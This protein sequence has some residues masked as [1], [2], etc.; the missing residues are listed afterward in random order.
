MLSILFF[1]YLTGFSL[2]IDI[3][4]FPSNVISKTGSEVVLFCS[5]EQASHRVILWYQ[6]S[7]GDE[8]LKLIGYGYG[9]FNNDSVEE[10]FKK[11]F[12]LDGDL[13]SAK[14]NLS[15]SIVGLKVEHTATY[16][17]ATR[18]GG[19]Y[20]PAYFGRG[21]KLTVLEREVAYPTV[22]VFYPSG[23]ESRDYDRKK[24]RTLL[25]VASDFYPDHV[26]VYWKRNGRNI[27]N[28][29]ATDPAAKKGETYYKIT[30]RLKI[31]LEEWVDPNNEYTCIVN[32]FDGKHYTDY[33]KPIK[34][35][36]L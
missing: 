32:F 27:T 31:P 8:D 22:N 13:Q 3:H 23:K 36:F 6:K 4:Q 26:S 20:D 33:N 16:Y 25:C 21:T 2:G 10:T 9:Q 12:R 28:G 11:H 30:S 18:T 14:K 17:C 34:G 7:P 29:V 1:C 15:L 5:H 19:N 35:L 24:K